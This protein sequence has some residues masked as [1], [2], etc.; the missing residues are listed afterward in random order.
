MFTDAEKEGYNIKPK[1]KKPQSEETKRKISIAIKDFNKNNPDIPNPAK[2]KAIVFEGKTLR[3][4]AKE[5]GI[6]PSATRRRYVK[7]GDPRVVQFTRYTKI[8]GKTQT[9]W[10]KELG[11]APESVRYR[12]LHWGHPAYKVDKID[13]SVIL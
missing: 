1:W 6:S 3:E 4:W 10:A 2:V 7:Y 9:Q 11:I 8:E 5:L 12:I 13:K